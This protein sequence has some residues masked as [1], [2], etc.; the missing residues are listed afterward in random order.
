VIVRFI[1][2]SE[3]VDY[4]SITINICLILLTIYGVIPVSDCLGSDSSA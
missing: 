4:L 3:I 1:D 2:V